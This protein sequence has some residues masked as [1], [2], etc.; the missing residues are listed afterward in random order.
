MR[1]TLLGS[2]CLGL[3]VAMPAVADEVAPLPPIHIAVP[4]MD[5]D[6]DN[7]IEHPLVEYVR[8]W[9]ELTGRELVIERFPFKRSIRLAATGQ[10]DF[11]FP[12][13]MDPEVDQSSLPFDYSSER[14]GSVNFV[15]YTRE[16]ETVDMS[17]PEN[18]RLS[19]FGGHAELFPFA[20]EEDYSVEGSL[21]KLKTGRIDGYIFADSGG[22]PALIEL[23]LSGIHR[24]FYKT[25]AVHAVLPRSERGEQADA[26]ISQ[27]V[28]L[29]REA[30]GQLVFLDL[31]FEDWQ[32]GDLLT[33]AVVQVQK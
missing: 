25:Y 5:D 22:D 6:P 7:G 13:I 15:L 31:P 11:H 29:S 9:S 1:F 12:L 17:H 33:P 20:I 21:M 26:F 27:A 16:G 10:V 3:L 19:T 23:G 4:A 18:Y 8:S 2:L 28:A 30:N 32:T 24:T 14:I